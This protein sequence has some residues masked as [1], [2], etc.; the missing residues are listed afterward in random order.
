GVN[1][2]EKTIR[3]NEST[4]QLVLWDIAGQAKFIQQRKHFYQGSDGILLVFDQTN[5]E[6]FYNIYNWY[7]DILR[8]NIKLTGC[9]LGNKNDLNAEIKIKKENAIKLANKFNFEYFETSAL[10]GKDL[11]LPFYKLAKCLIKLKESNP[12]T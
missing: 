5:L 11:E 3:V 1:I 9:L 6:S 2:C 10:T 4:V 12:Q 7:Q 8:D